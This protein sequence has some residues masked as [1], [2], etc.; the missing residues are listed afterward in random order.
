MEN[1]KPDTRMRKRDIWNINTCR[2][3]DLK[4]KNKNKRCEGANTRGN[5]QWK[6]MR[7]SRTAKQTV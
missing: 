2:H 1:D 4:E 3:E 7:Q 5:E 6:N